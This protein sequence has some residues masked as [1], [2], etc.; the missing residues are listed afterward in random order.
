[1]IR[2]HFLLG[3][4]KREWPFFFC[5]I[6]VLFGE[7]TNILTFLVKVSYDL[8]FLSLTALLWSCHLILSLYVRL[9]YLIYLMIFEPLIF[10]L[11]LI[12]EPWYV[13]TFVLWLWGWCTS[14][15]LWSYWYSFEPSWWYWHNPFVNLL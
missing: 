13:W 7:G 6:L 12:F 2:F 4:V 1:M 8:S 3:P 15:V 5:L 10:D 11:P 14:L 9:S